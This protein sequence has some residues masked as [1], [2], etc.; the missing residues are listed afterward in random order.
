MVD[1]FGVEGYF[2]PFDDLYDKMPNYRSAWPDDFWAEYMELAVAP[3]G[4]HYS[5][6]VP[7]GNVQLVGSGWLYRMSTIEEFDVWYKRKR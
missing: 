4:K 3:D 7:M 2:V 1:E 6:R 5:L